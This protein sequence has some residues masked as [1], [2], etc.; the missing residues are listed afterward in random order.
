MVI[1]AV[2][3]IKDSL[4]GIVLVLNTLIG[5][6]QELRAKRA[7]DRLA[8]L[9]APARLRAPRRRRASRWPSPSWC[10]TT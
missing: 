10:S 9:S 6:V 3:E 4:F 1:L 7:L 5:I 2:G 8:L